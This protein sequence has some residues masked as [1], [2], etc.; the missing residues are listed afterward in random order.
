MWLRQKNVLGPIWQQLGSID[1]ETGCEHDELVKFACIGSTD[2]TKM[3]SNDAC[4]LPF[5][6]LAKQI[7]P[8]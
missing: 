8:S 4:C 1:E 2:W 5:I 6:V 3:S 7:R